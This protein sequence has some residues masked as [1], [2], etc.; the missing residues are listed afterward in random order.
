MYVI[1]A[2]CVICVMRHVDST[3]AMS[4][5]CVVCAACDVCDVYDL[6]VVS[7]IYV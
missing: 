4:D 7:V 6:H 5:V 1:N 3:C 2:L